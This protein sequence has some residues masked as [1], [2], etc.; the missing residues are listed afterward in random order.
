MNLLSTLGTRIRMADPRHGAILRG[1]LTVALFALL[2]KLA[3]AGKEMAVAYRYGLAAEVDAY[4]FLYSLISW[5]IGIWCSVLT[6]VLVPLAARTRDAAAAGRARFRAE[7]LG[8]ALLAGLALALVAWLAISGL[9]A[10]GHSGLTERMA[11]LV[12]PVLP[13]MVMMLPLGILIALQS[14]W[15]LSAGQH[16][17]TLYDCIPPLFIAAAILAFPGA[18][19]GPL[20]WGTLAGLAAHLLVLLAPAARRMG[21]RAPRFSWSSPEWRPFF[22]GFGIMLAGQA[23][24]GLTTVIDQFYALSLG[25]GAAATLAYAN[26]VL[27]LVLALAAIAVSRATLP[28]FSHAGADGDARLQT[29]AGSWAR[30]MFLA[31]LVAV[32]VCHP[33]APAAVE[34]LFERGQFGP[35]DTAQVAEAL[36]FGLPQLPF[37]F[38]SMVLVSYALSQGCYRLVFWSGLI[39]CAGKLAGNV[40]LVPQLAVNGVMLATTFVYGL[41]TLFFLLA[42][43]RRR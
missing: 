1:M 25:T 7:L 35:G 31:G 4:Q 12:T 36:R 20:V 5:P 6:A 29:L 43:K 26:R 27:S 15:M 2:G 9:L 34:L 38:A 13:V 19:L 16:L 24:M 11:R 14:A 42:L 32:L 10:G 30:L 23:F 28:V 22:Q 8:M 21:G 41:N 39:G 17:N 37:C 3:S 18:G 40:L 33:L